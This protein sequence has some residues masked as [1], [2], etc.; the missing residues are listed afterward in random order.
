MI[1]EPMIAQDWPGIWSII[2]PMI[3]A[4]ETY[5]LPRDMSEDAA[6]A[7]WCAPD[8]E[9]F[10]ARSESAVVGS[11]FLRANQSGP[12]AHVCNAGYA[13]HADHFGKGIARALCRHSLE[14]AQAR[15][16]RAMQYNFVVSSNARAVQLWQH[17][18]S[19]I[20]GTLPGAFDHPVLGYVD[21]HVMFRPL[22][23]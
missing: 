13:V 2:E 1:V 16:Y 15:G 19:A 23:T 5:V 18:G 4:G 20:V 8:R 11:Y 12:G 7:Y 9:V 14:T 21:A 17:M 22:Q 6:R 10:I 3:R